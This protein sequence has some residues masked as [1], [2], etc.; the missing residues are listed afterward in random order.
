MEERGRPDRTQR[1][2][3]WSGPAGL[4]DEPDFGL[5]SVWPTASAPDKAWWPFVCVG[6][7]VMLIAVFAGAMAGSVRQR[8]DASVSASASAAIPARAQTRTTPTAA[9]SSAAVT[10]V[11]AA[12]AIA[13]AIAADPPTPAAVMQTVTY[14]CKGY[15]PNGVDITYGPEGST[16]SAASLPFI[17]TVPLETSAQNFVTEAQLEGGGSVSCDTM[18]DYTD[19]SGALQAVSDSVATSGAYSTASA[20][21]CSD[22]NGGWKDC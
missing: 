3:Q 7:A 16:F 4:A 9:L 14:S 1:H 11:A 2:Q 18:V 12:T 17:E 5:S 8:D 21:V 20:Q 10:A 13:T 22:F 6:G 15:A 19:S